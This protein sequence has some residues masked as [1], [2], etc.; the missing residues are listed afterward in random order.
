MER[1]LNTRCVVTGLGM[2]NAIGANVEEC[3]ENALA[4]KSG[5][6][7]VKSVSAENCYANLGAEIDF[8]L[9]ENKEVDRVSV[10]CLKAS[11]EAFKDSGIEGNIEDATRFGVI[12]GSCV[13]GVVSIEEY[14]KNGGRHQQDDDFSDCK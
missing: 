8:E 11:E 13:G 10:L 6:E 5:I 4:G 2:V 12:M 3:W 1:Q 14:I 7:P 9:P